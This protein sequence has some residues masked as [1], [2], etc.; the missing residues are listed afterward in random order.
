MTGADFLALALAIGERPV[1]QGIA[2][3]EG[4]WLE[5]AAHVPTDRADREASRDAILGFLARQ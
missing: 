5:N 4:I 3:A 2:G 1:E